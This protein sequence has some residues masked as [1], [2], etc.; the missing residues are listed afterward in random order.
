MAAKTEAWGLVPERLTSRFWLELR[1]PGRVPER[2]GSWPHRQLAKVL[3]E[4][5]DARPTAF[6]SVVTI[7]HDGPHFEDGPEALMM[8]DGRSM[9]TARKHLA[10][11]KRA[12]A[13]TAPAGEHAEKMDR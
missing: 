5:M 13:P 11:T 7:S 2:K 10:S 3:R 9:S 4:F 1:E 6:I 12:F 8:A